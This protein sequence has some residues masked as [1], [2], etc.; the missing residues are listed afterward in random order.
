MMDSSIETAAE[1]NFGI[2]NFLSSNRKLEDLKA[3]FIESKP[4]HN[5]TSD[6]GVKSPSHDIWL[7]ASNENRKGPQLLEDGI[8]REKVC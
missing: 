4:K 6:F 5:L 8:S 7:S 1:K 3:E 2:S